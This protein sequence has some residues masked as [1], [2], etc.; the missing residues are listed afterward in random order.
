MATE[1]RW[2]DDASEQLNRAL[3]WLGRNQPDAVETVA[4][5]IFAETDR[6]TYQPYLGAVYQHLG[7]GDIRETFAVN[8]RIYYRLL[9]DGRIAEIERIQ[10]ASRRDPV[11]QE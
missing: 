7:R 11:F 1:V 8:Y 6:L 5:A 2:S 9:D 10:H 4:G 3:A